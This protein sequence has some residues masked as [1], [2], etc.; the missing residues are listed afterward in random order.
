M[1]QTDNGITFLF[2]QAEQYS[3]AAIKTSLG[4]L[5]DFF[6]ENNYLSVSF[7]TVSFSY[8]GIAANATTL[9][10][11]LPKYL[12]NQ[13]NLDR[14]YIAQ[15]KKLIKVLKIYQ[16][17]INLDIPDSDLINC[18]SHAFS[19][20]ISLADLI[21]N[22]YLQNGIWSLIQQNIVPNSDNETLWD[23]TIENTY[24]VV[25][26]YPYYFELF[27][28]ENQYVSN[29]I[30]G[31]IHRWAINYCA[32]KYSELLDINVDNSD[33]QSL[34]LEDIGEKNFL[35][36]TIEKELRI[37]FNDRNIRLLKM[38]AE[39]IN[40]NGAY[41]DNV[42][43]LYGKNKF[44]HVWE[45]G[46]SF[47]FQN[48]YQAYKSYLSTP[49][50]INKD[51]TIISEK[52]TVRPDVIR[53]VK[54]A[55]NSIMLI[56]DAKYYMF[57]FD[58]ISQRADNNPGVGDI[59]KQYFYQFILGRTTSGAEWLNYP[60]SYLNILIFP[61]LIGSFKLMEFIGSVSIENQAIDKPI[62]N[63]YLNPDILFKHY[64]A[65]IPFSGNQIT[66]FIG[67]SK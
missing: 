15:A 52:H 56:I 28:F 7:E 34:S 58:D 39:L 36:Y 59:I 45:S 32:D 41:G 67:A 61:G 2:E 4:I 49:K 10:C 27:S 5:Y 26:K 11:I 9:F 31:K 24:P 20:E 53:W 29:N 1:H 33:E 54:D 60:T 12:K 47:C 8:C 35:L 3:L 55:Q 57:K 44:E 62:Y 40:S 13:L 43:T 64:I 46:V 18:S 25:T 63:V 14:E 65:Q 17:N 23:Y 48:Q 50:W 22:D 19:S 30:I 42:Y 38:L 66:E 21:L 37:T 51:K 6:L 16:N